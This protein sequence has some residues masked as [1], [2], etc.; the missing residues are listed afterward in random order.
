MSR[1]HVLSRDSLRTR[2]NISNFYRLIGSHIASGTNA[3]EMSFLVQ[4]MSLFAWIGVVIF[5][6]TNMYE[7]KQ[8]ETKPF[9]SIQIRVFAEPNHVCRASSRTE[10]C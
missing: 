9:L 8:K 5:S 1:A 7:A 4:L 10:Q 6:S 2:A 3:P